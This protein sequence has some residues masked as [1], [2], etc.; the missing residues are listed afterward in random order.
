MTAGK[1]LAVIGARLKEGMAP[2]RD[3]GWFSGLA[4]GVVTTRGTEVWALGTPAF[5]R[6]APV[7]GDTLFDIGSCN[8]VFTGVLLAEMA[9]RREVRVN[10]PVRKHLPGNVVVPSR[11]GREITLLDLAT[12]TSGLPKFPD[13]IVFDPKSFTYNHYPVEA[14]YEE[15]NRYE[16]K[17]RPGTQW[18]YSNFGMGLLGHAL[19]FRA[20]KPYEELLVERVLDP[21][22]MSS[23]RI[24]LDSALRRRLAQGYREGEEPAIHWD[25]GVLAP[26][27]ELRSSVNDIL[28]FLA[29]SIRPPEAAPGGALRLSHRM[30]HKFDPKGEGG[31]GMGWMLNRAE[32]TLWHG[33]QMNG[34]V[35]HMGFRKKRQ[36]GLVVMINGACGLDDYCASRIFDMLLGKDVTFPIPPRERNVDPSVFD[37]YVGDYRLNETQILKAYRDGDRFMVI[38]DTQRPARIYAE[39]ETRF[40]MKEMLIGITF[41]EEEGRVVRMVFDM[42]GNRVELPKVR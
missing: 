12:H 14:M 25:L 4:A 9:V 18:E 31:M 6:P 5:D 29:A 39:S 32:D 21:L 11:D 23:T 33:G 17:R 10:D 8:K 41:E 36:E 34:F 1:G 20:G 42:N 3:A 30:W 26:A 40:F 7:D 27:G 2:F 13:N 24:T 37:R 28:K 22:G 15:M 16:L 19:G 35:V 38:D